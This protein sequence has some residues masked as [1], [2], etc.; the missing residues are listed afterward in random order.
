MNFFFLNY[1][2]MVVMRN[3]SHGIALTIIKRTSFNLLNNVLAKTSFSPSS[4]YEQ[5]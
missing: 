2:H 4:A 3:N 1:D 5:L